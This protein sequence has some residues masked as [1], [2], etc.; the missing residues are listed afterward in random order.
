MAH[1]RWIATWADSE[2][3]PTIYR[4]L[5]RVVDQRFAF[6]TKIIRDRNCLNDETAQ[7]PFTLARLFLQH[8]IH[9]D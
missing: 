2:D 4:G 1:R 8:I 5:A 3:K 6:G 9:Q 7:P